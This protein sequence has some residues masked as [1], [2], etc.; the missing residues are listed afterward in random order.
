LSPDHTPPSR[1]LTPGIFIALLLRYDAHRN[2]VD[3]ST[4]RSTHAKYSKTCFN[5]TMFGYGG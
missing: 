1:P 2:G 3:F 5:A 4:H